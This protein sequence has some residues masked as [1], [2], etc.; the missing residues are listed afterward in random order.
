MS[1]SSR[2]I[3]SSSVRPIVGSTR[4]RGAY[5]YTKVLTVTPFY[6]QEGRLAAT[7][8]AGPAVLPEHQWPDA[9]KPVTS[10]PPSAAAA[11][12]QVIGQSS[13]PQGLVCGCRYTHNERELE[14]RPAAPDARF[15]YRHPNTLGQPER[16]IRIA[17][18]R[19]RR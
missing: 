2:S 17:P 10:A 18:G 7:S 14:T 6:V 16:P 15:L 12:P 1:P 4:T 8:V 5:V 11:E 19:A 9:I 13:G 3:A